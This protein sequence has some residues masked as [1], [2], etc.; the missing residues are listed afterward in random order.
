MKLAKHLTELTA[1]KITEVNKLSLGW[2]LLLLI[3]FFV[4]SPVNVADQHTPFSEAGWYNIGMIQLCV[5]IFPP[6]VLLVCL[7]VVFLPAKNCYTVVVYFPR[8]KK[9]WHTECQ[10]MEARRVSC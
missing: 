7:D 10:Q 9:S 2:C 6:V 1:G 4:D 5:G 8:R 3:V